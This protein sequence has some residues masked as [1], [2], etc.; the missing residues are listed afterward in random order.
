MDNERSADPKATDSRGPERKPWQ[1][2]TLEI[3]PVE[4]AQSPGGHPTA[5]NDHVKSTS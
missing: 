5:K 1:P 4:S 3:T 2:P